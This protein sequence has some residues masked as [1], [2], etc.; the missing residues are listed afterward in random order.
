MPIRIFL[1]YTLIGNTGRTFH[2][3]L[4]AT[5]RVGSTTIRMTTKGLSH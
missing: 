3:A 1:M 2:D 4:N 5:V